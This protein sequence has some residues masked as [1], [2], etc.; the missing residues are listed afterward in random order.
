MISVDQM[1]VKLRRNT[2]LDINDPDWTIPDLKLVLNQSWWEILNKFDFR[3]KEASYTITTI[4]G[5]YTYSVDNLQEAFLSAA[6]TNPITQQ[7]TKL[8]PMSIAFFQENFNDNAIIDIQ[9][10]SQ[11]ALY[12]RSN[13]D[14]VIYPV[15]DQAYTI[16]VQM[17]LS[18]ADLA[19][20]NYPDIPREWD[21]II[22]YGAVWRVFLET[23]DTLRAD[24]YVNHQ[25]RLINNTVPVQSKEESDY[26]RTAKL[27]TPTTRLSSRGGLGR[28]WR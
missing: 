21:E 22:L 2:G 6:I 7:S 16:S 18:L 19:T 9:Y 26:T 3:E 4:A 27:T 11:P 24:Y 1:I 10:Q 28:L 15:P 14:L 25:A 8:D 13:A 5:D 23:G 12:Y 20:G 17:L